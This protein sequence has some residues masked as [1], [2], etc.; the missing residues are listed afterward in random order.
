MVF[1]F[2]C[3]KGKEEIKIRIEFIRKEIEIGIF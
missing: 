1:I 2:F 3:D